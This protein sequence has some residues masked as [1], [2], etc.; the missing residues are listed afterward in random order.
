MSPG[1]TFHPV[2]EAARSVLDIRPRTAANEL[3]PM[4]VGAGYG[5]GTSLSVAACAVGATIGST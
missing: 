4:A 1:W 2:V 5:R 3:G